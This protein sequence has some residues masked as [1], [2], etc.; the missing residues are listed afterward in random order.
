MY[1]DINIP[2]FF[3]LYFGWK[4]LKRTKIWKPMEMDFITGIP[5]LEETEIP[6]EPPKTFGQKVFNI[7]F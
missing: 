6:E 1:P 5:T 3:A 7:L 2:I 4:I